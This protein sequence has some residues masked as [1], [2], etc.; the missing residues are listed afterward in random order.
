MHPLNM[1]LQLLF[2]ICICTVEAKV[3][4]FLIGSD[5]HIGVNSTHGSTA[6][7]NSQAILEMLK[8]QGMEWPLQLGTGQVQPLSGLVL[9]GDL[10]ND[11]SDVS[12]C[13]S[14]WNQWESVYGMSLR[15]DSSL[16]PIFEGFGNHDGGNTSAEHECNI[17][18]RAVQLRNTL[19]SSR[20]R[21][22]SPGTLHYSW[23]WDELHLVHLNLY[24][25]E[26]HEFAQEWMHGSWQYPEYSR[27]FLE[28]DLAENVGDSE[29]PI[30]IFFHYGFDGYW[31]QLWWTDHERALFLET[32]SKYNVLAIFVGHTHV[33][34]TYQWE[35][36]DIV[37]SP[38]TVQGNDKGPLPP[39]FMVAELNF[40]SGVFR[41]AQREGSGWGAVTLLKNV[42]KA[43][44][45]AALQVDRKKC[46]GRQHNGAWKD[47]SEVFISNSQANLALNKPCSSPD[48]KILDS[49][50]Q[51][52]IKLDN[53]I[54]RVESY[55]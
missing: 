30:C 2:Y 8:T 9:T 37:N 46:N 27:S 31:S 29:R 39:S 49:A 14:Q 52:A 36:I 16:L 32:V 6:A 15:Q 35:G 23:D 47:G 41:V 3:V 4:T 53:L 24:P 45:D 21:N 20:I 40:D 42:S 26:E 5:T 25:G 18:R 51:E 7:R 54:E 50:V 11:G 17:V 10:I 34:M 44:G 48:A 28:A 43:K 38:S 1:L 22:I 13:T 55:I 12:K 33:A 19:R